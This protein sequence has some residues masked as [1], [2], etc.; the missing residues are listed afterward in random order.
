[1]MEESS[2]CPECSSTDFGVGR[3]KGYGALMPANK[4]FSMGSEVEVDLCTECGLILRMR[5]KNPQKF[6]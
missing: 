4:V 5:A 2:K 3:W 1:M 6:R